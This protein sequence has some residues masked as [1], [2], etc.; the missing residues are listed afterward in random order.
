MLDF[1]KTFRL[2]V[3]ITVL[4]MPLPIFIPVK[5]SY[6]LVLPIVSIA[7]GLLAYKMLNKI[8]QQANSTH[9]LNQLKSAI[10][11][12]LSELDACAL[13]EITT[14]TNELEQIKTVIQDAVK[15]MAES[16]NGVNSLALEQA[17]VVFSLLEN[18]GDGEPDKNAEK[19]LHFKEFVAE[20]DQVL[21]YF[22]EQ[23]LTTS[24]QSM[25]MVN[26]V[27]DVD[28]HMEK[29][30]RLLTDVQTIA[31]QTNLLALNAAIEAAR[32]GEAGRGFAVVADEVR[33]L[34]K[35]SDKF[36]EEIRTVIYDSKSN[37]STA[38][39]IIEKLASRDMNVAI[40]S[41]SNVD[42]MMHDLSTINEGLTIKLN[43]VSGINGQ[44]E[45]N[46][47]NA[48]RALQFEDMSRQLIEYIQANTLHINAIMDELHIGMGVFKTGDES[49]WTKELQQGSKR[50]S[51]MKSLW[52]NKEQKAVV[53]DSMDVGEI[54]LF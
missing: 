40:Q 44:I 7:W 45:M 15:T 16:F 41:K 33:N 53:Q 1:L 26:V 11:N 5:L 54:D 32:A 30:E 4:A 52:L 13:Q 10:D 29:I 42:T 43:Q 20:I 48:V 14:F 49:I 9:D 38:K 6:W 19:K 24:K 50:L 12:Y 22:I 23:I 31:D 2:P 18:Q 25:E 17:N 36:S 28:E 8:K 21:N 47:G 3:V 34:S 35:H 27:N 46:V 51:E 37:I 39:S